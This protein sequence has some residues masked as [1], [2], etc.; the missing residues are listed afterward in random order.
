MSFLKESNIPVIQIT[1]AEN[2]QRTVRT[3]VERINPFNSEDPIL[4]EFRQDSQPGPD[5]VVEDVDEDDDDDEEED[6]E[7]YCLSDEHRRR[8]II[9]QITFARQDLIFGKIKTHYTRVSL[10]GRPDNDTPSA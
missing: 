10:S 7:G 3:G 2:Y 6:H 1:D 8:K 9:I 5:H 4:D